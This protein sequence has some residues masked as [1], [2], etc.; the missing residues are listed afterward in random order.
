MFKL[1]LDA[2]FYSLMVG[3]GET[4]FAAFSLKLG[5]SELQA[6]A[7]ITL[8]I[9]FGG[10]AQLCSPYLISR[11]GSYKPI[12]LSGVFGQIFCMAI[13]LT[14]GSWFKNHY[15]Y[16]F[17]L[18]SIY[19]VMAMGITPAWS[20]WVSKLLKQ[21]EIR[22][23][24]SLRNSFVGI[25]T[26][27]GLII[28]GVMLQ[29]KMSILSLST[30]EFIFIICLIARTLSF[31]CLATHPKVEFVEPK[32]MNFSFKPLGSEKKDHFL[33]QF[34]IFSSVFKIGVFFSASFFTPYMLVYLKFSYLEYTAILVCAFIGRIFV[35]YFLRKRLRNFDINLMY[36]ISAAGICIIPVLWPIFG[37]VVSIMILETATGVMWGI[38]EICFL[39]TVF[40]EI[41]TENQSVYMTRY[42]LWH[43]I[44]IGIGAVLGI[45]CFYHF[46]EYA[47]IYFIIFATSTLLRAL[48]IFAFPRK[49]IKTDIKVFSDYFRSLGLRPGVGVV[50]RPMWQFLKNLKNRQ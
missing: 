40:E 28:S 13:L 10:I 12:V 22:H 42:N 19:W 6:G 46:K 43:T 44:S 31:I 38:F 1:L 33:H 39:V 9:V 34:F 26:L 45:T 25:G 48:S 21:D 2:F 37:N 49:H 27:I 5:H 15:V 23:F 4:Y 18:V 35:G 47:N 14:L 16:L 17:S 32:K 50:A 3:A 30:F 8:P 36:L 20:S 11:I 29:N 7:L 41:P 24:F